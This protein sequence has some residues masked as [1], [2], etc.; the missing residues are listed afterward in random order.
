MTGLTKVTEYL[1]DVNIQYFPG[2]VSS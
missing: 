2:Q 1:Q